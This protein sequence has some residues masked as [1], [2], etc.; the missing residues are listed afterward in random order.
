MTPATAVS[1][2][3]IKAVTFKQLSQVIA[4]GAS[5]HGSSK[6]RELRNRYVVHPVGD[7]LDAGDHQSLSLFDRLHVVGRLNQCR[8][9]P[10]IEP[11]Y[12]A[13]EALDVQLSS[14]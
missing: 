5:A 12:S 10:G 8:V 6:I 7:L 3:F 9:R 11:R 4:V 1:E 13:T 2:N 14:F